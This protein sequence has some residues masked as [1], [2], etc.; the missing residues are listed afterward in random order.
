MWQDKPLGLHFQASIYNAL[1]LSTLS[2]VSQLE[3]PPPEIIQLEFQGPSTMAKG[4][5]AS[6]T[7]VGRTN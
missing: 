2:Y 6:A 5:G 7:E 1:A 4:P 3:N